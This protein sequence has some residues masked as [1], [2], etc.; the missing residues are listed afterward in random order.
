LSAKAEPIPA[1]KQGKQN[2]RARSK[3]SK[4]KEE[5]WSATD[6]ETGASLSP[7]LSNYLP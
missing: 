2:A 7:R 3:S 5:R 6:C 1:S 4:S